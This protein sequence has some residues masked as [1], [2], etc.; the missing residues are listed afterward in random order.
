MNICASAKSLNVIGKRKRF[1]QRLFSL[2]NHNAGF[3]YSVRVARANSR[4]GKWAQEDCDFFHLWPWC[5]LYRIP[6]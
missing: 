1:L 6:W 4:S 2:A 3:R 5:I